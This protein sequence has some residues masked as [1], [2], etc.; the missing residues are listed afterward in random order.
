[1]C[2]RHT[3]L[4]CRCQCERLFSRFYCDYSAVASEQSDSNKTAVAALELERMARVFAEAVHDS[5]LELS[6]A[7][8]QGHL[9]RHKSS[10]ASALLRVAP[11]LL[12]AATV[13][14]QDPSGESGSGES[15]AVTPR[16]AGVGD[17]GSSCDA[18]ELATA[19]AEIAML[20]ETVAAAQ[21][22]IKRMGAM[23]PGLEGAS[24]DSA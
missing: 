16:H 13:A 15:V 1:M 22:E 7:D 3:Q 6:A 21:S 18:A 12:R 23:V 5:G 8:V 20:R 24:A 9:M 17:G 4:S 11:E 14:A 19:R 10:P 2:G